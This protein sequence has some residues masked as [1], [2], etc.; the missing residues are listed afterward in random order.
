MS[1]IV[2]RARLL[3]TAADL[4]GAMRLWRRAAKFGHVE[5]QL[6]FGLA[7]YRGSAGLA[8]DP[9]EAHMWLNKALKQVGK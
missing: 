8:Q 4:A 2:T 1:A 3:D 7:Q 6:V 9:E 5:A